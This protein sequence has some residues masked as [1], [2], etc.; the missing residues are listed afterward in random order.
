MGTIWEDEQFAWTVP[1]E[2]HEATPIEVA[3]FGTS[4]NCLSVEPSSFVLAPGERRELRMR[5]N[6]TSQVKDTGEVAVGLWARLKKDNREPGESL[7]PEWMIV[8]QVRRVLKFNR[9]LFY[10][11]QH[12]ELAQPL[13]VQ[14]IPLEV[15]VPL[16]SLSA[17][18]DLAGFTTK[19]EAVK[20]GKA[21]LELRSVTPRPLGPF[22]GSISLNPVLKGA[23]HLPVQRLHFEGRIVPDVEAVPPE[24]LVGGRALGETIE[25]VVLL[26]SLT[27]RELVNVRAE[28]EGEGLAIEALEGSHR[29]R[30]RQKVMATGSCT[31][32]IR[33]YA[34]ASGQK[35]ETIVPVT[36]T[37]V[38]SN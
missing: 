30:I 19:V 33:V 4:C 13:P 12:S 22:E 20:E 6:L 17:E 25:D 31:N 32:R 2:N 5:I 9:R 15:L 28:A 1:I 29:L 3:S 36:Y 16:Q 8:G 38:E 27:G 26:R 11:G 18:C 7:G 21:L 23:Q 14:T 34:Q 35:V 10:V 37:G 24:V